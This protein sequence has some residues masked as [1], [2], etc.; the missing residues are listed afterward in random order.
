MNT[1]QSGAFP[2]VAKIRKGKPKQKMIKTYGDVKKEI[3]I[4][5]PDLKNKFRFDFLPGTDSPQPDGKPSIR[6]VFH[7]LHEKDYVKYPDKFVTADGYE[8]THIKAM[9]A[10]TKALD[11]WQWKNATYNTAG[12]LV[13]SADGEKYI[14]KKDPITMETLIKRG[15]PYEKFNVGD[16]VSYF[17]GDKEYKLKLKSEGKLDLFLHYLGEFVSF[18]LIT[19]SYIDSL[20]IE[21]QLNAIQGIANLVNGGV[22]GGIPLDIYRVEM[23][24]PYQDDKGSHK[25]KQ[26]FIQIKVDSSVANSIIGR[27][28]NFSLGNQSTNLL[29]PINENLPSEAYEENDGVEE[30]EISIEDVD[31]STE[32]VIESTFPSKLKPNEII[33]DSEWENFGKLVQIGHNAGLKLPEYIRGE[34]NPSMVNGATQYIKTKLEKLSK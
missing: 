30:G 11:G 21:K 15:E 27:M 26:W 3:E 22:V 1:R 8:V 18:Q 7:A 12:A 14:T 2:I 34:M 20:Y 16:A 19:N 23:D 32:L 25:G 4:M 5:G 33:T 13:A 9:L 31:E 28:N 6:Q 17:R 29:Q 10:T 24:T